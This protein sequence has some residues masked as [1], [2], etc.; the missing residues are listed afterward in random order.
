M[1]DMPVN[2][3]IT[4][5]GPQTPISVDW[6]KAPFQIGLAVIFVSGTYSAD[7]EFTPDD[8]NDASITAVWLKATG[9]LQAVTQAANAFATFTQPCRFIRL[10]LTSGAAPVLR[11]VSIQP[12]AI[13]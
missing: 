8:L 5:T 9:T 12:F 6:L 3:N 13:S 1:S 11:F 2:Q 10:N 7:L 4:T